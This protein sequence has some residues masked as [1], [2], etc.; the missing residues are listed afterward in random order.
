[1][2][3]MIVLAA[4]TVLGFSL[5]TV[6]PH[7]NA[8]AQTVNQ[9]NKIIATEEFTFPNECTN[10]LMDVS[11][12]TF[13]SCHDQL[14][15]DGTVDEK[16]AIRQDVTA[17]GLTTGIVWH[18]TA[19]FQVETI[20]NDVC[21]FSFTNRGRVNLVSDGSAPNTMITFDEFVH[22]QDCVLTA[23]QHVTSFNC[24]GDGKP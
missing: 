16:C 15:A 5:T 6:P 11:D 7:Q 19:T 1:M 2:K 8:E 17:T 20:T 9:H 13:V 4:I 3:K 18:G 21:N 10:E 23:D 24:H 14:R 22:M 12:T